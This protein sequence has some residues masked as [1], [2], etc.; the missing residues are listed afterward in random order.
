MRRHPH[1]TGGPKRQA[2]R[3]QS[4]ESHRNPAPEKALETE[5]F[6]F[7]SAV[8]GAFGGIGV[9]QASSLAGGCG[10]A[11]GSATAR[12]A[13]V[14]AVS[15]SAG[16]GLFAQHGFPVRTLRI[17]RNQ[18]NTKRLWG[19]ALATTVVGEPSMENQLPVGSGN[20]K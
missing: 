2:V 12:G 19:G 16:E 1:A 13:L 6:C 18:P 14:G 3:G 17:S 20:G 5:P 4:L 15:A 7:C 10:F 11:S 8:G 9:T